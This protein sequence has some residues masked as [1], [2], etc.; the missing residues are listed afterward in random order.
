MLS[1]IGQTYHYQMVD[2]FNELNAE[3]GG[4]PCGEYTPITKALKPQC[5]K[6]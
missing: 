6:K 1:Y 3:E 4:F 5:K 2:L